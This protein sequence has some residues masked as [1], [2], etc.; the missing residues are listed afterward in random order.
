MPL[1]SLDRR[2]ADKYVH[3]PAEDLE[4][5]LHTIITIVTFTA[6]P[7]GQVR[8]PKD[9]IPA[10]RWHNEIDREQLRKD[11]AIDLI[12]YE[13]EMQPYIAEYW[14]SFSPYLHRLIKAT[15]TSQFSYQSVASHRE[16]REI[17]QEALQYF[18]TDPQLEEAPCHYARFTLKRGRPPRD[19]DRYPYKNHRRDDDEFER[20]PRNLAVKEVSEWKDSVDG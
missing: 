10:A 11:K 20:L 6:G 19:D 5:L 8:M 18:N 3:G 1:A 13:K 15:W 9:H 12:A 16:F 2:I 17:L 14:Q 4:S 7:C